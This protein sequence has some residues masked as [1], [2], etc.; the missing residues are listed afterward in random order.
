MEE[1]LSLSE[2]IDRLKSLEQEKNRRR[3]A[4]RFAEAVLNSLSAHI[5]ILDQSGVIIET[6]RAWKEFARANAIR[7]RP[8][9]LAVNYI[10][11]CES[12]VGDWA[13]QASEVAGGIRAVIAGEMEEFVIDYPCHSPD[14]KR[15]FY[16]RAT[17][18][19]GAASTRVVVSHENITA[20]KEAEEALRGRELEL[21][22]QSRSLEE[23]N[24]ALKVLLAHRER[25]RQELE[26]KVLTNVRNYAFP[27]LDKLKGARLE[28]QYRAYLDILESHLKEIVSPFLHRLSTGH[29]Q[30]TPQEIQ[31]AALVKDGRTTKEI[32]RALGVSENAV[33]FHRK[34]IRKKLGLSHV[35]ANLR[36]HLLSLA[37]P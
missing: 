12:A 36:S 30:L 24:T 35:K 3:D 27:Y 18:L 17:R 31:V 4:E 16:M 8:D 5:A 23:A 2:L 9:T 19:A 28:P 33:E 25:D 20:L 6:N 10:Q 29:F 13:Q 37:N 22:Q 1:D 32:A 34:N 15:W 7:M 26:E 14:E 11:L 21:Q